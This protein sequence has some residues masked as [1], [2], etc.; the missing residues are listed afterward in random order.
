VSASTVA[1][2][3]KV[4]LLVYNF[5]VP[6]GLAAARTHYTNIGSNSLVALN[7]HKYVSSN[8]DSVSKNT[9]P[10]TVIPNTELQFTDRGC[11][12]YQDS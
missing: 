11:L 5:N 9:P 12:R 8:A 4:E 2:T 1:Q 6:Q 10:T 7:L 3:F